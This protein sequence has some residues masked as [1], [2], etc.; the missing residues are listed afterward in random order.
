[1]LT[2][3]NKNKLL[4]DIFVQCSQNKD[5]EA[6]IHPSHYGFVSTSEGT[7]AFIVELRKLNAC[8]SIKVISKDTLLICI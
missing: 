2:E 8:H 7:D 4:D 3:E 6:Y 5:G 1:M